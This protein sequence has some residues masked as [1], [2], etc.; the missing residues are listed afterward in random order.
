MSVLRSSDPR[1]RHLGWKILAFIA[2]GVGFFVFFAFALMGRMDW[3]HRTSEYSFR[4]ARADRITRG[5]EVTLHGIRVGRCVYLGLGKDGLPEGKIRV[6]QDAARWLREDAVIRLSGLD[7][8]SKPYL[9]LLP[10]DSAK[11]ALPE[12]TVLPFERQQTIGDAIDHFTRQYEEKIAPQLPKIVAIVD[13]LRRFAEDLNRQDGEFRSS[14]S[15]LEKISGEL[16]RDFPAILQEVRLSAEKTRVFL[17][18]FL[19]KEGSLVKS[20]QNVERL[21]GQLSERLPLL[22]QEL[23]ATAKSLKSTAKEVE[24]LVQSA[25]PEVREVVQSSRR[26]ARGAEELVERVK[27]VWLLRLVL[28]RGSREEVGEEKLK[29]Q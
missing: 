13:E 24:G 8:L 5:M 10:G 15:R 28:P 20:T 23:E 3:F 26:A 29:T 1:F 4:P 19:D 18:E 22:V 9:E 11:R 16:E 25:I 12:G 21:T 17:E 7:P 27:G 14:I 6:R 2:I